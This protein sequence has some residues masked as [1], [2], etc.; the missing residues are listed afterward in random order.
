MGTINEPL[1]PIYHMAG[2]IGAG[3]PTFDIRKALEMTNML[4]T[5][6]AKGKALAQTWGRL[7]LR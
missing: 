7:P 6:A 2:F 4:I 5:D 3:L 1:L